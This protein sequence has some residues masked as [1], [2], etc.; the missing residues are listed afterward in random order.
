MKSA[1]LFCLLLTI[2]FLSSSQDLVGTWKM[3]VPDQNGEM[4]PMHA[5]MKADGT[6]QLDWGG[7][8]QIEINGRY[9]QDDSKI[10]I[11]DVDGE[12]TAKGVYNWKIEGRTLTMT[13]ISDGCAQRGG[14][15]GVMQAERM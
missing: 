14:P 11:W 13:R 2:P 9:Q 15:D 10:T 12:C 7:D 4:I 5:T 8:G 3:M 6:Y 1:A